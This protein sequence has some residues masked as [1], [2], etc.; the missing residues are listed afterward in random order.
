MKL[1]YDTE[2]ADALMVN[3]GSGY[4]LIEDRKVA[5]VWVNMLVNVFIL[6][7]DKVDV[8]LILSLC[9]GLFPQYPRFAIRVEILKEMVCE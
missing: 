6:T 8:D 9:Y 5:S 3:Y 7:Q 2:T 1:T 4:L